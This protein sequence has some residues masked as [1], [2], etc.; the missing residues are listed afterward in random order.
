MAMLK[1]LSREEIESVQAM[2]KKLRTPETEAR[3]LR[4]GMD[5]A[6]NY[7]GTYGLMNYNPEGA[8]Q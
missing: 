1:F 5:M 7:S 4:D 2:F 3:L 6:E 8:V